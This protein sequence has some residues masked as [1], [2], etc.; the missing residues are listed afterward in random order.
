VH[1]MKQVIS[2]FL[3]L[4]VV[5]AAGVANAANPPKNFNPF[6]TKFI[7]SNNSESGMSYL[8]LMAKKI[9]PE[10][11]KLADSGFNII[12][13]AGMETAY[14]LVSDK[15]QKKV[16]QK[17]G[18]LEHVKAMA[19]S[20][21]GKHANLDSLPNILKEGDPEGK[22][23]DANKYDYAAFFGLVSG[24]GFAMEY[25]PGNY[26]LNVQYDDENEMSGRSFGM[27]D[28]RNASDASDK[29]YLK[30]LQ[31]YTRGDDAATSSA[32]FETLLKTLLNNDTAGYATLDSKPGKNVLTDFLAV[33]TAEQIRNLMDEQVSPHWDAALLEVTLLSAFHSA[34]KPVKLYV[35]DRV[36]GKS[37]FTDNPYEQQ[38]CAKVTKD[39]PKRAASYI[40]YWQFSKAFANKKNCGR[41][42]INVTS[43]EFRKMGTKISAYTKANNA[44][45]FEKVRKSVEGAETI[46]NLYYALS[47]FLINSDWVDNEHPKMLAANKAGIASKADSI[48]KTWVEFLEYTHKEAPAITKL[49]EEGKL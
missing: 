20:L 13:A 3:S 5:F 49:I 23:N 38:R 2:N 16:S 41:S 27:T 18:G 43:Q 9:K 34:Q 17:L 21:Q 45:L 11:D 48:A 6:T 7:L 44:A 10:N 12:D 8:Q 26:S 30:D 24:G 31:D 1:F 28:T 32:F 22:V 19:G 29:E 15:V 35:F 40:D 14:S 37:V 25:A 42:G 39:S 33:M 47:A 4:S 36:E 46:T